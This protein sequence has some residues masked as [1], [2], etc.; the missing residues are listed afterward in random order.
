MKMSNLTI[1]KASAGSGKTYRLALE[2]VKR[3]IVKPTA[4]KEILAVTFTNKATE[5]MKQRVLMH[6]YGMWKGLEESKGFAAD[7]ERELT[8]INGYIFKE[9]IS[10]RAGTAL[11]LILHDY[12]HLRVETIDAFFQRIL[13]E[14]TRELDLA[15]GLKIELGDKLAVREAV[16][17]LMG[18]MKASSDMLKWILAL[19]NEQ[20][21]EDRS[22]NVTEKVKSF[23]E[24]I[25]KDFYKGKADQLSKI[26]SRKAFFP[27][28][29]ELLKT[30]RND[31]K[32]AIIVYADRF[33]H[34]M[35]E[36][37]MTLDCFANGKSGII[38]Y[39]LKLKNDFTDNEKMLG[40][41]VVNALE[42]LNPETWLRKNDLKIHPEWVDVVRNRLL[43]LLMEAETTRKKQLKTYK[44][45]DLTLRHLY[46][47][48][49]L[50]NI[51]KKVREMN[52][53]LNRFLLS[54]TCG[55]LGGLIATGDA[56]FIF[57]KTG[58]PLSHIMID[59]FQDTSR[60][61]WYTFKILLEECLSHSD[62]TGIIVGD[63]K[64]SIYRWRSGDWRLLADIQQEMNGIP[65]K[66]EQLDKNYRSE[67]NIIA[68]NNRF[69]TIAADLEYR[70]LRDTV[71]EEKAS[72]LKRAY[73]NVEQLCSK[74]MPWKGEISITLLPNKSETTTMTYAEQTLALTK[75]RIETLLNDGVEPKEIA[76]LV[77]SNQTIQDLVQYL[78]QEFPTINFVSDEA[79]RLDSSAAVNILINAMRLTIQNDN[80]LARAIVE[81]SYAE[82]LSPLNEATPLYDLA[83][84]IF[85]KLHL[86]R[87]NMESAY[88]CAFFDELAHFI[89]EHNTPDVKSFLSYWDDTLHDKTI[90]SDNATGIRLL[91]IHKSKGLEFPHVLLPFC[92]WTLEKTYTL[93]CEPT[94]APYNQLP[95]VPVDFSARGMKDSIYED[96]YW[97]EHLQN[98][99][100]NLNLLYVAFTRASK[101]LY[102]IG[103]QGEKNRRS[104]LIEEVIDSEEWGEE[105]GERREEN[106]ERKVWRK[107]SL[108]DVIDPS[109][110]PQRR[111]D[112]STKSNVSVTPDN[113]F[114]RE[115][116]TVK[117]DIKPSGRH[118][119]FLQSNQSQTFLLS[120][121]EKK[122]NTFIQLGSLLHYVLSNIRTLD[123]VDH[124]IR[125]LETE[126]VLPDGDIH[127]DKL[128]AMLRERLHHPQV[129]KWFSPHWLVHN[130]CNIVYTDP[131]TGETVNRR[132]DRVMTDGRQ[133]IVVDFKFATP[134]PE[135]Q[136]QVALYTGLLREM[137]YA[138]VSGYLWYVYR[139]QVISV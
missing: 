86:E 49:L 21:D 13:R 101:S 117:L 132:P 65:V 26:I 121:E 68:F 23:G 29:T 75:E 103:K 84:S 12:H 5:E 38:G 127:P 54:D 61:Q 9:R 124:A 83:W 46:K 2:I 125:Q 45:A 66:E 48:R 116:L 123:D 69:F 62:S 85:A 109:R 19:V 50:G 55:L 79:F 27:K 96:A 24:N 129:S 39:F 71:G 7:V 106:G 108:E 20:M 60:S 28:Y 47:L 99:V 115:P 90:Q 137:G 44:S 97:Q 51:E 40:K 114:I 42:S 6:L 88:V 64:Q 52:E 119:E 76:V 128:I 78:Q 81:K 105:N 82:G 67:G 98:M 25:L 95:I 133:T 18:E 63:V 107:G 33:E 87:F 58:G 16:D 110:P 138:N 80:Q 104:H 43:P 120:D 10:E 30:L 32:Q 93:W 100:D 41:R 112:P 91:T 131:D 8:T 17:L 122:D 118:F 14:L 92:D 31:A 72:Q 94:E 37:G 59:E 34:I 111:E 136:R 56:P 126:G 3:L 53:E 135:H 73:Q 1:Y 70:Q 57:E 89:Q 36:E 77:R 102:V 15:T 11:S 35:A 4:Y 22:W 74:E 134:S 139:N 113:V 130:E